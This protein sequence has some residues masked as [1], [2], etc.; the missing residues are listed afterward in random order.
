MDNPRGRDSIIDQ[1]E[2]FDY[3]VDDP[4]IEAPPAVGGDER[5]MHVRAYNYWASL[6]G[7]RAL[8]SIED[9]NPE[10]IED[11]GPHG[12]L[13]DF[14]AGVDDPAVA[15]L[16]SALRR[17]CEIKGEIGHISEVPPRSLISRL[18]D[19]YLQILANAAPIGFEAE[20]VN[21]RGVEIMYRGILMPFSSDD[22]TIDFVYGVI[23]W[24]EMASQD[25]T[26]VLT[27]EVGAALRAAPQPTSVAHIWADGPSS[28]ASDGY[29]EPV[30]MP[31]NDGAA[32]ADW[33]AMARDCAQEARSSDARSRAAL[34]RAIGLAYD[35]A[36]AAAQAPVDYAEMLEDAGIAVQARSPMTAVVKLVFGADYDKT[37][38]TEYAGALAHAQRRD[39]PAGGL[40][41]YL[42][43]YEG[44]LKGLVRDERAARKPE[45][46]AAPDR[47]A[48]ARV[49]LKQAAAID[50]T[51]VAT[52]S[53]GLAVLVARREA[54]GS[55][56]I[57]GT[58]PEG[59]GLAARIYAAASR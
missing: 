25:L 56:S 6:L 36:L 33:L 59:N 45:R 23:N 9:L 42:E 19:H 39:M 32:L 28:Q 24:K 35:F 22:D 14:T 27:R 16:G 55:L 20:F 57:V 3:A 40:A 1:D 17:E 49:K 31:L 15:Y 7:N 13:L 48:K 11:F 37:R 41:A 53:D 34:Y 46:P 18:T 58:L 12:V 2:D 50:E 52:D 43:G 54:D 8:P 5:R 21:Q 29:A 51:E 26:D 47:F 4:A 30:S 44:G 10:D 38:L